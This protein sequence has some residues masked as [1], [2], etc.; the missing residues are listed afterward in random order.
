MHF[1]FLQI[2]LGALVAGIDA[3]RNYTD[4]PLMAG[5]FLPPTPFEIGPLWRNF[6]ENAG[7]GAV[8]A[9]DGRLPAVRLRHRRLGCA[10]AARPTP[11]RG[12]RFNAVLAML[13]I[14]MV[15]G[16]VTVLYGAPW[17]IAIVHQIGAVVALGAD[18]ARAL[19]RAIS[20]IPVRPGGRHDQSLRRSDG[21]PAR[22]RGAGAGRRAA[23]LGSG[24]RDAARRS[25]AAR[26][27][28]GGDG[29]RAAR[30]P[31]RSP[32]RRVARG[33]RGCGRA[34]RGGARE[35]APYPPRLRPRRQGA[36][37][38]RLRDRARHQ[39]RAGHMG[40]GA[41]GGRFRRLR[42]DASRGAEAQARGGRGAQ[43]W[44]RRLRRAAAGLRAGRDRRAA[45]RHVRRAAPAPRPAARHGARGR[46]AGGAER[47]VRRGGADGADHAR[48]PGPSATT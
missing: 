44:R 4:W 33:G 37:T 13:V 15:L 24:N 5:G 42:A 21:V 7:P 48:S 26:R 30:P 32:R 11:T 10:R 38:P 35:P 9:P 2:L 6:F 29:E 31:R 14:Q 25:R 43:R 40:R 17:Q 28:D 8:H 20:E 36:R 23:G 1:A 12:S 18:P 3:G 19:R 47:H 39:R 45:D 22:D 16:I 41:G 46:G 27:G 34:R